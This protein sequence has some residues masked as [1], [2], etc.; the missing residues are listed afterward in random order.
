[1]QDALDRLWPYVGEMFISDDL[2]AQLHKQGITP[3]PADLRP[4]FD[5]LVADV[6]SAATLAKPEDDFAHKGG[7]SGARHTEH[8]GHMLTEMQ[9][10]Q[11]AYPDATW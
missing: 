3:N 5:K 1:M 10:L 11:R 9:W 6:F 7:K 4:E 2:D 8:L